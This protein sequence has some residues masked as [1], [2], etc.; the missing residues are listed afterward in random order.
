MSEELRPFVSA[1]IQDQ[2]IN[3]KLVTSDNLLTLLSVST[4]PLRQP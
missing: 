2:M 1:Y 3:L 4:D